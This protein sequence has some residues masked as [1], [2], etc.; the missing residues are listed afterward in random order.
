MIYSDLL[1]L[2]QTGP[3]SLFFSF[4][5]Y[6]LILCGGG[7]SLLLHQP[8]TSSI[9]PHH[10]YPRTIAQFQALPPH[11]S[12]NVSPSDQSWHPGHLLLVG[13]MTKSCPSPP[14]SLTPPLP[15]VPPT[16]PLPPTTFSTSILHAASV[17]LVTVRYSYKPDF[18]WK[19]MLDVNQHPV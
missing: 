1:L 4:R 16:D 10:S 15:L 6:T 7:N 13:L 3:W 14:T 9:D 2:L 17:F 18:P 19:A 12:K 8:T 5:G 11:S